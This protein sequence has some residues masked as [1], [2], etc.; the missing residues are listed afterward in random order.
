M[1]NILSIITILLLLQACGQKAKND[2]KDK[3]VAQLDSFFTKAY[4]DG[5]LNGNVLIAEKGEVLYQKS[6]GKA[7]RKQNKDLDAESVFELA[8]VSKQFTAMGV[9]LLVQQGK[10]KYED[11]LRKFFPE[12]PYHNITIKHLLQHTSGLPDYMAELMKNWD[13][14]KIATNNDVIAILAKNKPAVAFAPG[15]KWEYS[16][17]GYALL[18]SII[19]KASG[20]TFHDYL[21]STIFTP[22]EMKNTQVFCRR[23]EKRS[24]DNYAYGYVMKPGTNDYYLP[25]SLPEVASMVYCLDGIQG[26]GTVNSTTGD[27]LKWDRALYTEK[28]LPK[29]ALEEAFRPGVLNNGDST[30][31]GYGWAVA[32]NKQFGN[33]VN[34]SGGWPGYVTFIERHTSNDKT[35]IILQNNGLPAP[36][37]GAIRNILYGIETS[38]PQEVKVTAEELKQY[39]GDYELAPEFILSITVSGTK[40]FAQATGQ[41]ATEIFKEKENVYFLKVVEA[42][43]EFE[44]DSS[45]KVAAVTLFQNGE[46]IKGKKIE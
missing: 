31:Y 1:K 36:S 20:K 4:D 40:I 41:V 35:I 19:E 30:A 34:H 3:R 17:T 11:S 13:E 37:I 6:F 24:L 16:N 22:L 5:K 28:L 39:V 26:D 29:A 10:L 12:L 45:G 7:D 14:T 27:L 33:I 9:M 43:L 25:D 46:E 32:K 42:K 38:K 15:D 8:S 21:Q 18:A 2:V 44:K 23:F